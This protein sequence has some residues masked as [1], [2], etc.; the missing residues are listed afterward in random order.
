FT[1]LMDLHN[2]QRIVW[3]TKQVQYGEDLTSEQIAEVKGL[4]AE[5][6]DIFACSLGEVIPVPGAI[7]RLNVPEGMTF[8]LQV[9][10]R[11]LTPPQQQFLHGKVNEMLKAGII[12]HAPPELV[13]C[14]ATMVLAKKAH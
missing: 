8:N 13:K 14:C 6:A 9:Q 11:P 12:E 10:Q 5:Y 1:R 2:P 4:V 3:I 7:H